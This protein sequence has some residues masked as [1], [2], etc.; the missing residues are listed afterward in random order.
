[1][2]KLTPPITNPSHKFVFS[3]EFKETCKSLLD[4]YDK[5][6]M[7]LN[8]V[9]TNKTTPPD[10]Y[11]VCN[12]RY[13]FRYISPDNISEFASF[14]MKV[15]LNDMIRAHVT[16]VEKFA[17]ECATTFVANN[18]CTPFRLETIMATSKYPSDTMTLQD[19]VI[20]C[21]NE[22]FDTTVLTSFELGER[23]A[24][25]K[26]D[27]DTLNGV[28]FSANIRK[29]VE[30]LPGLMSKVAFENMD[31]TARQMI[32]SYMEKFILFSIS[33]NLATIA[34]M[35]EFCVPR[36]TYN[37]ALREHK[38]I[39]KNNTLLDDEYFKE[40]V[41]TKTHKPIWVVLTDT[42]EGV[43]PI[44]K[45]WTN[46]DVNHAS[47]SLTSDFREVF[48]YNIKNDGFVIENFKQGRFQK[49][50]AE[51]YAA[52]VTNETYDK[53][54]EYCQFMYDHQDE[55][56]YN[57][58]SIVNFTFHKD[59]ASDD[60]N[61]QVCSSFVNQVFKH[62]GIKLGDVLTPSPED[63]KVSV[64]T[65][66]SEFFKVYDGLVSDMDESELV[67]NTEKFAHE[68]KT[69][70]ISEYVTECCLLKT[71]DI[72]IRNKI[73]FNI[74]MKNMVLQD[75]HPTFKDTVSAIDFLL[76]NANSPISMLIW[77]YS[78][79]KTMRPIDPV[80]VVRMFLGMPACAVDNFSNTARIY[81][82][83]DF[84]SDVNWLD[85]ITYGD[86]Y[87][88]NNYRAED[89][90]GNDNRHPIVET[91][92]MIYKM[93]GDCNCKNNTD[94]ANN[95]YIIGDVMKGIARIY[96]DCGIVNCELV[97]DVLA[98]FGEIM[99]K[100]MIRLYNSHMT[101]MVASD[102]MPDTMTPGYM[103]K[104]YVITE[105]DETPKTT[106]TVNKTGDD[107]TI[108]GK[109]QNM[110]ATARQWLS[111]QIVEFGNWLQKNMNATAIGK[112]FNNNHGAEL[113]WIADNQQLLNEI[114]GKLGEGTWPCNVQNWPQYK[115][116]LEDITKAFDKF[117]TVVH[118]LI[119]NNE[120]IDTLAI[121][122]KVYPEAVGNK[123]T[124]NSNIPK[125]KDAKN[126]DT[127]EEAQMLKKYFLYGNPDTPE[128]YN[129]QLKKE[130][131][132][133]LIKDI[134]QLPQL[135]GTTAPKFQSD[136]K[137]SIDEI[138]SR[139][140]TAQEQKAAQTAE[141]Q[142]NSYYDPYQSGSFVTEQPN[143]D[144][145]NT[146]DSSKTTE[147]PKTGDEQS[148]GEKKATQIKST[149]KSKTDQTIDRLTTLYKALNDI[150]GSYV[151]LFYRTMNTDFYGASYSN[152]RDIVIKYKTSNG[153]AAPSQKGKQVADPNAPQTP[154]QPADANAAPTN[155][156][157]TNAS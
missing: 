6:M 69:H 37:A 95:I 122:K 139:L 84:H 3:N 155:A 34:S 92:G 51:V 90:P 70:A 128:L 4:T 112:N 120:K 55:T 121:K 35:I 127:S 88:A 142:T 74:N 86:P 102:S 111:K 152:L 29:I 80:T 63:I 10:E 39:P 67:A 5:T 47:I 31:Y 13:A 87:Q 143:G 157:A 54:V 42:K 110:L 116:P 136:L 113:K 133:E 26:K 83:T 126:R 108:K 85:K 129:G 65:D 61:R 140:K 56:K 53:M 27:Y 148:N 73:P 25:A 97:R 75:M 150:Q 18:N 19:L 144:Q 77:K 8:K 22:F 44:I 12:A 154:A 99:T 81:N 91:L 49:F 98:V 138:S 103:Y 141:V 79:P 131:F 123:L 101:V 9:L 16:D 46:S 11:A 23:R 89:M 104:E 38:S 100:C 130:M 78:D 36:S 137:K 135:L 33:L 147:Q 62:V 24:A 20:I 21:Q 93:Y 153:E 66:P 43:S 68:K 58:G 17:V 28:Y 71:N 52:Y 124:E 145:S 106:I 1:M 96:K 82:A 132:D 50:R 94:L 64:N 149:A 109:A 156:N 60:D 15:L 14:L 32:Q 134:G 117:P 118:E 151:G 114:S 105:A 2:D 125:D 119:N 76:Q 40:S 30:Q 41:D 48:S 72:M 115:I 57:W 7:E 59:K 45:K 107:S 146:G